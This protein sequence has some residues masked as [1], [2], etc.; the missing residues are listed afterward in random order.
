MR[1]RAAPRTI[2]GV[3]RSPMREEEVFAFR[4][5]VRPEFDLQ[6]VA[7]PS[8][9]RLR[10]NTHEEQV[11]NQNVYAMIVSGQLKCIG[12]VIQFCAEITVFYVMA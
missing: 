6:P 7:G 9:F 3:N 2:E 4:Y 1:P 8:W 10:Q 12:S 11:D 5:R